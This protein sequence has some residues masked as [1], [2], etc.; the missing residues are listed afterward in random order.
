MFNNIII[1]LMHLGYFNA[2]LYSIFRCKLI[3]KKLLKILNINFLF[4]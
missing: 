3:I 2:I 4:W 1:E